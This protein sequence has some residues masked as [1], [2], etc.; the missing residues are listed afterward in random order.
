MMIAKVNR[1]PRARALNEMNQR[2][3]SLAGGFRAP[4]KFSWWCAAQ[5]NFHLSYKTFFFSTG[6]KE[7]LFADKPVCK[8]SL[9][10]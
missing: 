9:R 1:A 5:A 2:F 4:I 7:A 6:K 3:R 10:P 8:F